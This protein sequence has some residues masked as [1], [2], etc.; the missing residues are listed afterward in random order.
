MV[1]E[2]IFGMA[3]FLKSCQVRHA[4]AVMDHYLPRLTGN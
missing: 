4:L 3:A 2:L 1:G